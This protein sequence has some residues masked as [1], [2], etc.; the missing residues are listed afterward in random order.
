MTEEGSQTL[1]SDSAIFQ[2]VRQLLHSWTLSQYLHTRPPTAVVT[3]PASATC[4][5]ALRLLATHHISSAP[6]FDGKAY[7][8]FVDV[9]DVLRALL[10]MVNVRE[11]TEE[12]KEYRLR[13]AGE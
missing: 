10:N 3:L 6:V 8:G 12:A 1:Q 9:C 11:L 7:L 2:P 13:A 4:A 5:Q